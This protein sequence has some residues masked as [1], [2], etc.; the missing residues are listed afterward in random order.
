MATSR[1]VSHQA[2]WSKTGSPHGSRCTNDGLSL[3]SHRDPRLLTG[4]HRCLGTAPAFEAIRM[5][6]GALSPRATATAGARSWLRSARAMA[7][8]FCLDLQS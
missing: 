3:T 1:A 4:R 8:E 2:A 6:V 5:K 7:C